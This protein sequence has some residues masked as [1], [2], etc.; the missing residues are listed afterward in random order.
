M[1]A[2]LTRLS[3]KIAIQLHLMVETCRICSSRRRRSVRKLLDTHSY[4]IKCDTGIK[5][6]FAAISPSLR[7]VLLFLLRCCC[8]DIEISAQK[9]YL[10]VY[11][12]RVYTY[13]CT[14]FSQFFMIDTSSNF[15]GIMTS[16]RSILL[17]C[18]S[19]IFFHRMLLIC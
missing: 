13:N 4:F 19:F 15:S 1:E 7:S 6:L 10:I 17:V 14:I 5:T 8:F 9:I 16:N 11:I 2:K 18:H 12:F 3:H